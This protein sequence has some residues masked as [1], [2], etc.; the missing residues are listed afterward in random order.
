LHDIAHNFREIQDTVNE[1]C[2]RVDRIPSTVRIVAVSK[3]VES[4]Q[5]ETAIAAGITDFGENR[6]D[7][8]EDR[9]GRFPHQ[10]WH[11]IGSIQTNKL[12]HVVGHAA[13]IHSVASEHALAV[14]DR[15]AGERGIVQDVLIEVNVSGEASK[16]GVAATEVPVLIG[17][18]LELDHVRVCGLMTMAPQD[19][20]RVARE[21]VRGLRFLRDDLATS[22]D[23]GGKVCLN[24]LSMGMS[25]DF[26]LAVEEGATIVRIGRRMWK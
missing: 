22:F 23:M 13:L 26:A 12:K 1:A 20:Q 4:E 24:E 18:A 14:I 2:R 25:D 10:N 3:T 15:L 9:A 6:T 16:D 5:I 8:F 21:T 19:D 7:K 17:K 11:F